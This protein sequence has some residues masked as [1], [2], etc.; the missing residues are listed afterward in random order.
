MHISKNK[1]F[2][3]LAAL[4]ILI[5][6]VFFVVST[7]ALAQTADLF[8]GQEANI[9]ADIGLSSAHPAVIVARIINVFLGFLG[10]ITLGMIVYAGYEWMTSAGDAAKIEKAKKRIMAAIVGLIIILASFG[11]VRY[12]LG[13]YGGAMLGGNPGGPGNNTG[14]GVL[15]QN[16]VESH[17]PA[18]NALDVVRNT[19]IVVTFREAINPST[20][21]LDSNGSGTYGDCTTPGNYA[22][23]DMINDANVEIYQTKQTS[24][25]KLKG[26][27]GDV[28]VFTDTAHRNFVF[29][30]TSYLGSPSE[31]LW[32]T[33]Y[34]TTGIRK[35]NNQNAFAGSG[36]SWNFEV[37]TRIDNT[38][39][40]VESIWPVANANEPKNVII[41]INFDEA[42]NPLAASGPSSSTSPF[43]NL[44][45]SSSSALV[46]GAFYISNQYRTVEFLS[47]NAC[48]VNS[49]GKTVFCLPGLSAI[50][51][52]AKA[53]STTPFYPYNGVLDMADN[54]L[55]GNKDGTSQGP[56]T[57]SGR[58]PYNE[59]APDAATQGDDY[60]WH[61][62]TTNVV[63][64]TAPLVE[65]S[66][67]APNAP[68]VLL[69]ADI[70]ARFS[71]IMMSRSIYGSINFISPATSTVSYWHSCENDTVTK[72]TT[73]HFMHDQFFENGDYH[74]QLMSGLN[75]V[76]QNCYKPCAGASCAANAANPSCCNNVPT[77]G[78]SCP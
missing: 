56:Q 31:K 33:V 75:D 2:I 22:T 55:D 59:N 57:E 24:A 37:G 19:S 68:G 12:F 18:R 44:Q 10:I 47:N 46:E 76:Y 36:Y 65:V 66:A 41:Q 60:A 26:A 53:A 48:G 27:S 77:A 8:G 5:V 49:C 73:L 58:P 16:I 61:F 32:Y 52:L 74:P 67:P 34:L 40:K 13:R 45:V 14:F 29:K 11:L 50:D 28:A 25:Q 35:A 71:K 39:P 51:V 1:A 17:Y 42:V 21:I 9:N 15:G 64:T 3:K 23:C 72:K 38:P 30:P 6:S 4:S 62:T 43:Q 70:Y 63:D 20:I 78:A 69:D 7:P 54:S